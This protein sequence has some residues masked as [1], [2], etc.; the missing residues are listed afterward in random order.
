MKTNLI[1]MIGA[2]LITFAVCELALRTADAVLP[3]DAHVR[4]ALGNGLINKAEAYW[5]ERFVSIH[6]QEADTLGENSPDPELGWDLRKNQQS[7]HAAKICTVNELGCRSPSSFVHDPNKYLVLVV[8]DSFTFGA[9]ADDD[10]TWPAQLESL[11]PRIQVLNCGVSAYGTDQMALRL[12]RFLR[13]INPDLVVAAFI[14]DDLKRATLHFRDF[15]KPRFVIEKQ[16]L[17]LTN[18]PIGDQQEVYKEAKAELQR[19]PEAKLAILARNM[20]REFKDRMEL[21]P[22]NT[23]IFERMIKAS[24][25][26]GADFCLLYLPYGQEITS[27]AGTSQGEEFFRHFASTHPVLAVNPRQVFLTHKAA[28]FVTGHYQRKEAGV[29]A[30]TMREAIV[31]SPGF[32]IFLARQNP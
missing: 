17:R 2:L 8:G 10:D 6:E 26:R 20:F 28:G 31:A 12:E 21:Y 23:L 4:L 25:Y 27:V 9:E 22:L 30:R 24:K 11:E 16:E 1:L 14:G 18:T 5:M 7:I 32:Q 29:V 19:L 15:K 3:P 13:D